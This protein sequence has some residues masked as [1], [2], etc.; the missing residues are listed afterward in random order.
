MPSRFRPHA[1]SG[2]TLS[3]TLIAAV[4]LAVALTVAALGVATARNELKHRQ[5]RELLATLD[6]ALSMYYEATNGWPTD[7]VPEAPG[8]AAP[9]GKM[10]SSGDRVI[11]IITSVS[12]SRET[13]ERAPRV[14][15]VDLEGQPWGTLQ[16]AWGWRLRCLTGAES[17]PEAERRAVA[18]NGGRP[19]FISAGVDGDFGMTDPAA[20]GDNL[21][22]ND[23]R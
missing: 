10:T 19:I 2:M 21:Q 3:E 7:P 15:R 20:A 9:S 23:A 1:Q 11:G 16:D 5:T 18:A 14:L 4:V 8:R 6:E 12:A 22:S 13:L 17:I